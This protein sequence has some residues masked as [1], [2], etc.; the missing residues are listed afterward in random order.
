M[1]DWTRVETGWYRR[2]AN[3]Y[4][5]NAIRYA[6]GWKSD[7][8]TPAGNH[9]ETQ[10]VKTLSDAK[11]LTSVKIRQHHAEMLARG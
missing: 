6:D 8:E 5:A 3:G 1:N 10:P 2:I 4:E 7:I 11:I 9:L